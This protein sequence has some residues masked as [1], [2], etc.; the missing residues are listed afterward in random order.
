MHK[1]HVLHKGRKK[2]KL[3]IFLAFLFILGLAAYFAIPRYFG[4]T[5]YPLSYQEEI[6]ASSKEFSVDPNFVAAV[7]F[8]ES[9]FRPDAKSGVGA[10]GLMQ[11]MPATG[12]GIAKQLGD[13]D[14]TVA[15]L[16]EP[17][18]NIRYGT[19][20]LK[21]NLDKY[22][23]S[24]KLVLMHYNG[25]PRAVNSYRTRGTLPRETEGFVRKVTATENIYSSVYGTWWEPT[26]KFEPI[27]DPTKK[28]AINIME[29]WRS[30]IAPKGGW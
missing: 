19:Y 4:A 26:E 15:K 12:A 25:G 17:A 18:R 6:I 29:F 1:L 14:F 13:K 5:V 16:S 7:I 22:N 2:H 30:L 3:V 8:T 9:R 28:P 11:I 10:I 27:N 24:E 20:Y 23:G 21:Q